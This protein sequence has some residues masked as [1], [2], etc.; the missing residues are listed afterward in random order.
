MGIR[1]SKMWSPL[2]YTGK[3]PVVVLSPLHA[4]EHLSSSFRRSNY[5]IKLVTSIA[6]NNADELY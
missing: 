2:G 1:K 6:S 4:M 5:N 3:I